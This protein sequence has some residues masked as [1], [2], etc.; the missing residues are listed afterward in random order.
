VINRLVIVAVAM[1]L[2]L[3]VASAALWIRSYAADDSISYCRD[4][5]GRRQGDFN[6]GADSAWFIVGWGLG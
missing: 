6:A 5:G 4:L 1:S 3:C 2:L